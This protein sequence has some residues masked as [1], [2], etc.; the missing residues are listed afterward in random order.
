[1]FPT[2][3]RYYPRNIGVSS[4]PGDNVHEFV[5]VWEHEFG[6]LARILDVFARHKAKVLLTHSQLEA[7]TQTV[8]GTYFCDMAR[9]DQSVDSLRREIKGLSFVKA[10]ESASAEH[11]LFDK[12][13]FPITVWG[14]DR[15]IVMRLYS[16]LSI[17]K[18][19]SE[20][21]GFAGSAIMFR[22]GEGYAA[23]TANQYRKAL[24]GAPVESLLESMKDGL[25]A[26]G[27][28][29][30]EFK[31]SKNGYDVTVHDS[32]MLEGA[33]E[34]NRFL[35]GIIAGIL[36][37]VLSVKMKIVESKVDAE[38]GTVSVRLSQTL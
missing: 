1:M 18:R 34:P 27:W 25:R 31:E 5:V 36:E 35:C 15:V 21:L 38:S 33:T 23:E 37:S 4:P 3:P 17:E 6:S 26:M 16:L 14:A 10:V 22:E 32:A 12:F 2:K 13:L 19:L 20:E 24:P 28:G 9:A 7:H 30:F 11:S 8:V 29:L